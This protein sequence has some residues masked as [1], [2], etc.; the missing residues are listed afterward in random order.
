MSEKA[1]I[2]IG[3]LDTVG[4]VVTELGRIY[5]RRIGL[6]P[7]PFADLVSVDP[8]PPGHVRLAQSQVLAPPAKL[9]DQGCR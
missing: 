5:E 8:N 4:G 9:Y 6:A 2:R 1:K 7:F 3:P